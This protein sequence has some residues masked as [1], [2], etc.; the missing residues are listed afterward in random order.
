MN[1]FQNSYE[2]QFRFS[3]LLEKNTQV[4]NSP[5]P[6]QDTGLRV[7]AR[8]CPRSPLGNAPVSQIDRVLCLRPFPPPGEMEIFR[9]GKPSIYP[10]MEEFNPIGRLRPTSRRL[11]KGA[12]ILE[13]GID[14]SRLRD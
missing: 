13:Q 8:R 14:T 9:Y 10:N 4:L 12:Q 6:R 7:L 3:R 5:D 1:P 11:H 2:T